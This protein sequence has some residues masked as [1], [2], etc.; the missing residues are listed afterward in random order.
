MAANPIIFQKLK[1]ISANV[2]AADFAAFGVTDPEQL[3]GMAVKIAPDANDLSTTK[4]QPYLGAGYAQG[5]ISDVVV[6]PTGYESTNALWKTT[7]VTVVLAEYGATVLAKAAI[8][9]GSYVKYDTSAPVGVV[10]ATAVS[11]AVGI[12]SMP[13]QSGG[14]LEMVRLG[15][16]QA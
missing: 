6:Q 5:W 13:A 4:V 10:A 9:A 12:A 1:R 3:V 7:S 8:T 15:F 14:A 16:T 2:Y 11:D